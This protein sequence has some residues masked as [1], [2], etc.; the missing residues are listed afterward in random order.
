MENRSMRKLHERRNSR[1]VIR[2]AQ[3]ERRNSRHYAAA[4]R[5]GC[6]RGRGKAALPL[7]KVVVAVVVAVVVVVV[8]VA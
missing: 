3:F 8:V 6:P 7:R 2:E 4:G 5:Q 1:G